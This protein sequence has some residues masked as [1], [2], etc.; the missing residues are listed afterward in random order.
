M[1]LTAM[2]AEANRRMD[3][4]AVA[5]YDGDVALVYAAVLGGVLAN[6]PAVV[7]AVIDALNHGSRWPPPPVPGP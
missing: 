3:A 2:Q 7:L 5:H 1:T 6:E 4:A